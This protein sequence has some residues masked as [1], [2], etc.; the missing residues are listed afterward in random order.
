FGGFLG[1][2]FSIAFLDEE[3]LLIA[4]PNA[5]DGK[6]RSGLIVLNVRTRQQRT[7]SLGGNFVS[8]LGCAVAP[9][10]VIYAADPSA[11]ANSRFEEGPGGIVSV[12]AMT[13]A[14]T[15]IS[16]LGDFCDPISVGVD[17]DGGLIV[18]DLNGFE[19]RGAIFRVD[20]QTG[21]QSILSAGGI[22][23]DPCSVF[24][25]PHATRHEGGGHD[26]K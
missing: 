21:E 18:C 26:R 25:V 12:D 17:A 3:N 4:D 6:A 10:R 13:G 14:Q 2:P 7:L 19:G 8:A 9:N 24:I 5:T 16:K 11:F 20:A 22:F 23:G 15:V 1:F